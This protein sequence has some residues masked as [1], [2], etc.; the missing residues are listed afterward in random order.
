MLS[1]TDGA[2]RAHTISSLRAAC[3]L[4]AAAAGRISTVSVSGV[5][6]DHDDPDLPILALAQRLAA[7]RGL[8]VKVDLDRARYVV[9]FRVSGTGRERGRTTEAGTA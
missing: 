3:E 7:E 1:I 4:L 9:Q 6:P 8:A 5:L 2:A